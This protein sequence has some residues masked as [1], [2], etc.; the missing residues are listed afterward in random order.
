MKFALF[1][2]LLSVKQLLQGTRNPQ[3]EAEARARYQNE[4][5]LVVPGFF[6]TFIL[7]HLNQLVDS[8]IPENF[9]DAKYGPNHSKGHSFQQNRELQL[10]SNIILNKPE[11]LSFLNHITGGKLIKSVICYPYRMQQTDVHSMDW[12]Q[13]LVNEK[14]FVIS[15][16]IGF[17]AFEGGGFALRNKQTGIEL[18]RIQNTGPGDMIIAQIDPVLEHCISKVA[19]VIPRLTVAGWGMAL[20]W[21]HY[22]E[23]IK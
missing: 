1:T 5:F 16:N 4:H 23:S 18:L 3:L 13:D 2:P 22:L 9:F 20:E 15:I 12:H 14:Q 7:K 10:F 11:V 19:G 8:T 6:D 21:N 17:K